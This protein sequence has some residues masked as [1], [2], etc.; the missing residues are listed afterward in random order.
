MWLL[1]NASTL[2]AKNASMM[3]LNQEKEDVLYAESSFQKMMSKKFFGI[4]I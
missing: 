1:L 3:L 2:F 4:E